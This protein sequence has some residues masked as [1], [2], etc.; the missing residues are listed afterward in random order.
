MPKSEPSRNVFVA[1]VRFNGFTPEIR[2]RS[3]ELRLPLLRRS[4]ALLLMNTQHGS[5]PPPGDNL[6]IA[7]YSIPLILRILRRCGH[8]SFY[9]LPNLSIASSARLISNCSSASRAV[10]FGGVN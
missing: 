8:R 2:L 7:Y 9:W 3:Y 4:C 1:V 5:Q 10:I 6:M